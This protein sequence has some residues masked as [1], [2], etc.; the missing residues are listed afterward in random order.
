MAV[1]ISTPWSSYNRSVLAGGG[2]FVIVCISWGRGQFRWTSWRWLFSLQLPVRIHPLSSHSLSP[3]IS[4]PPFSFNF[5]FLSFPR[6]IDSILLD[7]HANGACVSPFD[8]CPVIIQYVRVTRR[9]ITRFC[10]SS[11]SHC[12]RFTIELEKNRGNRHPFLFLFLFYFI[13]YGPSKCDQ[14]CKE[15]L[16]FMVLLFF[17]RCIFE[18]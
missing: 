14:K 8:P 12:W 13:F 1:N 7:I 16:R 10:Q 9:V 18:I 2:G 5:P 11:L 3:Y 17:N 4:T 6:S 15:Y